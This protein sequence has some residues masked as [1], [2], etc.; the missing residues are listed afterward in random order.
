M[1][2]T[3]GLLS[4]EDE[5]NETVV[6]MTPDE[7][8]K[9]RLYLVGFTNRRIKRAKRK[10]NLGCFK[11]HFGSS[12]RVIAQIWEDLQRTNIPEAFVSVGK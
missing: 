12:P 6:V 2:D 3:S 1:L 4:N 9:C 7:I 11:G 10:V 8:L 5:H